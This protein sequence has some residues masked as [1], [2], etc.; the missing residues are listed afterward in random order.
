MLAH[1]FLIVSSSKLL[2][3]R[4]GIKARTSSILGLWFP[5]PIYM[6]FE[7]R[8]DLGT[9][10]SGERSLPFG[11]LVNKPKPIAEYSYINGCEVWIENS[12]SRINVQHYK[13][14]RV[15]L[16]NELEWQPLWILFLHTIPSTMAFKLKYALPIIGYNNLHI[17][18]DMFGWLPPIT[19]NLLIWE[20]LF[21]FVFDF[22]KLALI[23]M[24][25]ISGAWHAFHAIAKTEWHHNC[26]VIATEGVI[27]WWPG[28][29]RGVFGI[30][31]K[32][33][34]A[35]VT[36]LC[37]HS[38]SAMHACHAPKICILHTS[39]NFEVRHNFSQTNN[40][41]Q[42]IQFGVL[43]MYMVGVETFCRKWLS[44]DASRQ[45]DILTSCA[46]VCLITIQLEVRQ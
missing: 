6:F 38:I 25:K 23:C 18:Q 13:A 44:T 31:L 22:S 40:F 19:K 8:F 46:R 32:V 5:W 17:G 21:V 27:L 34:V 20:K 10:D 15:M 39:A 41:S 16:N 35:I 29:R 3:T 26:V 36:E 24:I 45:E 12:I 7:M 43:H 2:I 30:N 28:H 4:T 14:C 9:L 11:L 42:I 33:I 37:T 1:S